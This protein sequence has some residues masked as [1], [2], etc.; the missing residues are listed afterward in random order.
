M[1]RFIDILTSIEKSLA[2]LFIFLMTFFVLMDIG[3]REIFERGI[4]WAQK[5]AV[6]LMIWSGFLGAILVSS[7]ASHL[8]PEIADKLWKNHLSLFVRIQNF[9][10]LVFLIGFSYFAFSYVSETKEF[11]DKSVILGVKLWLL[12]IIIPYALFSMGIR[13]LYFLIYPTDQLKIEKE[14][15]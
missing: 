8:R 7:K 9:I 13:S 3:S 6:Y 10:L 15:V 2:A 4:P 14:I 12:Q 5:S 1:K 11:G